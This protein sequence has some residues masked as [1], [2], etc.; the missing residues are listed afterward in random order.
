MKFENAGQYLVVY[1]KGEIDHHSAAE[2]RE[3]IDEYI[4][5]IK[6]KLLILNFEEV[7]FMDSSGIGIVMGRYNK[8][9]GLG[10]KVFVDG[11]GA[12]A[13]RILEMSGIYTIVPKLQLDLMDEMAEL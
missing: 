2:I 10:G 8:M 9:K 5:R 3:E 13:D 6:C 11:C 4:D 12:Y 7:T 1:L